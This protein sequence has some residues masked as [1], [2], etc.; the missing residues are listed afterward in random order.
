[1]GGGRLIGQWRKRQDLRPGAPPAFDQMRVDERKGRIARHGD[2]LGRRGRQ[3]A[4]VGLWCGTSGKANNVKIDMGA[5]ERCKLGNRAI[6]VGMLHRLNQPQMAFGQGQVAAPWQGAQHRNA[7]RLHALAHQPF[8][9]RTGHAVQDH[10]GKW[11]PRIKAAEPQ[12][13]GGGGLRLPRHIQHQH[14]R[15]AHPARHVG[16]GTIARRTLAGHAVKQSH[17]PFGQHHV[18]TPDLRRNA[19][20]QIVLHRPA[21]EIERRPATGRAVKRGVDI[22]RP[23]LERLHSQPVFGQGAQQAQHHR[24][25]ACARCGGGDHQSRSLVARAHSA[26]PPKRDVASCGLNR[27]S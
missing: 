20:D 22:V 19:S 25:L 9:T 11:Q 10:P 16:A 27:R 4:A 14:D 24:G 13:G 15:P 1:M 26:A 7:H 21:I 5:Q 18:R 3:V 17:R 12:R 2:P 23:A 6:K 8:M